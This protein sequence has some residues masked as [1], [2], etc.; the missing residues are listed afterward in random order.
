MS[1]LSAPAPIAPP[2][3]LRVADQAAYPVLRHLDA[4]GTPPHAAARLVR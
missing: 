4:I 3:L 2:L 1:T